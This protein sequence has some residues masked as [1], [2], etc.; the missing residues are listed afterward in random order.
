MAIPKENA[1]RIVAD[2]CEPVDL[3]V[4]FAA[5]DLALIGGVPLHLRAGRFHTKVFRWKPE[6]L[7]GIEGHGKQGLRLVQAQFNR[8]DAHL[9]VRSC[10]ESS[11]ASPASMIGTPLRMG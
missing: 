6:T 7:A 3:H 10:S 9:S 8:P 5:D 4:A 1:H 2:R 11:R